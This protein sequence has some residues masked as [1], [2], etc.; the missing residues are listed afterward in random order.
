VK[1][2]AFLPS[3]I[4]NSIQNLSLQA[5]LSGQLNVILIFRSC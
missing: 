5:W 1:F 3:K 2:V 4:D